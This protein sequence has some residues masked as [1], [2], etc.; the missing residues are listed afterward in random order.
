MNDDLISEYEKAKNKLEYDTAK[1]K[2]GNSLKLY[3]FAVSNRL[4]SEVIFV[5]QRVK[6]RQ[7]EFEKAVF[8]MAKS[9]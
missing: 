3:R 9:K 2:L 7:I 5:H 1:E 6:K 8:N 4:T